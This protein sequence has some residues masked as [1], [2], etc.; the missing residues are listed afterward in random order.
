[1]IDGNAPCA[2]A[3]PTSQLIWLAVLSPPIMSAAFCLI[4]KGRGRMF[5]TSN[6]KWIRNASD[7]VAFFTFTAFFYVLWIAMAI[8]AHFACR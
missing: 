2:T 7:W 5:R 3:L 1:M 6:S 8:Y 4:T